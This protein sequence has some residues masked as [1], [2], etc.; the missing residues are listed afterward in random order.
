MLGGLVSLRPDHDR[1]VAATRDADGRGKHAVVV[2]AFSEEQRA[3][4]A[5]FLRAQ[6][7]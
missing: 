1:Y 4:A 7:G 6:G 2:H 3:Q 5:E